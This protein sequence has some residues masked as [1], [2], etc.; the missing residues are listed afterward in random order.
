[1]TDFIREEDVEVGWR[2]FSIAS[3]IKKRQDKYTLERLTRN[4]DRRL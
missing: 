2:F 1:M 4:S 3:M